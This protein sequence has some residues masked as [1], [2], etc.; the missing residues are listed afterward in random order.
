MDKQV[1]LDLKRDDKVIAV[2]WDEENDCQLPGGQGYEATVTGTEGNITIEYDEPVNGRHS[3]IFYAATGARYFANEEISWRLELAVNGWISARDGKWH[4]S[5]HARPVCYRADGGVRDD[6]PG[7]EYPLGRRAT[8]DGG[9]AHVPA[10][11]MQG[12]IDVH[13]LTYIGDQ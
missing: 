12:L 3:D 7:D 13:R 8:D 1:Y 2:E 10:H 6:V 9:S 11:R 5:T 4:R